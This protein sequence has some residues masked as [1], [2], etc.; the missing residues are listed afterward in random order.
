[1]RGEEYGGQG[2]SS[3]GR[4]W[5]LEYGLGSGWR[6]LCAFSGAGAVAGYGFSLY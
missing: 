5:L 3:G 1:M 4:R 6:P 2:E